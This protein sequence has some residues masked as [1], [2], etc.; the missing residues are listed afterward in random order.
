MQSGGQHQQTYSHGEAQPTAGPSAYQSGITYAQSIPQQQQYSSTG[1]SAPAPFHY[2]HSAPAAPHPAQYVHQQ[3]NYVQ[4]QVHS[5]QPIVYY[6]HHAHYPQEPVQY[7]QF[8]PQHHQNISPFASNLIAPPVPQVHEDGRTYSAP[9][10]HT[11]EVA[12]QQQKHFKTQPPRTPVGF[13]PRPALINPQPQYVYVQGNSAA[14]VQQQKQFEQKFQQQQQ[15]QQQ[16]GPGAPQKVHNVEI[17]QSQGQQIA[18]VEY[19]PQQS[20]GGGVSYSQSTPYFQ[21]SGSFGHPQTVN[22]GHP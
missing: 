10:R 9:S 1:P 7:V 16:T 20:S 4:H 6:S 14:S 2:S 15:Q 21:Y 8:Q 17:I 22:A 12:T 19:V 5:N 3:P 18:P 13:R 11:L